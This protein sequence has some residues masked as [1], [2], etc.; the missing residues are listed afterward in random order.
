MVERYAGFECQG[1]FL[2]CYTNYVLTAV[3]IASICLAIFSKLVSK[4][5]SDKLLITE[6]EKEIRELK[7]ELSL[8]KTEPKVIITNEEN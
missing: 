1:D 4:V 3:I 2:L 6:L 8:L 5:R 7:S